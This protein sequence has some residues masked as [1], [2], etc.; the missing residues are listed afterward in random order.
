MQG[1]TSETP[2]EHVFVVG[3]PRTGTKLIVDIL[4]QSP[5]DRF[6]ISPENFYLGHFVRPGVREQLSGFGD[7]EDDRNLDKLLDAMYSGRFRGTYWERLQTG[8][9]GIPREVLAQSLRSSDRSQRAIYESL[10]TG[11]PDLSPKTVVGDKNPGHLY[12]V[13]QILEWFP[14][15]KIIHMFRDPRAIFVSEWRKRTAGDAN[16]LWRA[17]HTLAIVVHVTVTWLHAVRLHEKYTRVYPNNYYL[18][19]FEDLV[20]DSEKSVR[21]LCAYLD[22][23]LDTDAIVPRRYDSSLAD[24]SSRSGGFDEG[25]LTRWRDHIRPWMNQ[26]FLLCGRNK[27]SRFGYS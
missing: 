26:W 27:L 4:H 22:I 19:K 13:P 15:A 10:I 21:D 9:L 2:R 1:E 14:E 7:L 17:L 23:H 8:N 6:K 11:Y 5:D 16:A 12:H 20:S 24:G 18:L 25:T 3:L